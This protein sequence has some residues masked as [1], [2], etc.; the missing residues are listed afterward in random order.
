[1]SEALWQKA[2]DCVGSQIEGA[3]VL[4]NLD[5]GMYFALNGPA[6]D[7]WEALAEP[8]T[9]SRLIDTLVKKYKITREDCAK[10]VRSLLEDLS[11]KGL[12]KLAD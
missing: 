2:A 10:S 1:M 8:S 5:G 12:A 9:E 3:L 6:A 4:L 11:S 7:V